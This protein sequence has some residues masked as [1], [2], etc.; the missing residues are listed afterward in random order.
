VSE[1]NNEYVYFIQKGERDVFKIGKARNPHERIR[2]L[3]TSSDEPL[4]LYA[5]VPTDTAYEVEKFFH[6]LCGEKRLHGEWFGLSR[7][8]V[9][10]ILTEECGE[11]LY[12]TELEGGDVVKRRR[13]QAATGKLGSYLDRQQLR[14]ELQRE[15]ANAFGLELEVKQRDTLLSQYQERDA[16]LAGMTRRMVARQ[17]QSQRDHEQ[18][19]ATMKREREARRA[20]YIE[21]CNRK[22]KEHEHWMATTGKRLKEERN[23]HQKRLRSEPLYRLKCWL[24]GRDTSLQPIEN[25]S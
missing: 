15:R 14:D 17:E 16:Y 5:V 21:E 1:A 22:I 25:D 10:K 23:L 2:F 19:M 13:K 24:E 8:E 6:Q 20:E 9:D 7:A 12:G 18:K 3:A 11:I 4:T